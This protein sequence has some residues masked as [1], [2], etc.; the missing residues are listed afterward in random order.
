MLLEM[1]GVKGL[2]SVPAK[3]CVFLRRML[4]EK[5]AALVDA[6]NAFLAA[7]VAAD[8]SLE[9]IEVRVFLGLAPRSK[10]P[11]RSK[12]HFAGLS[13]VRESHMESDVHEDWLWLENSIP[14]PAGPR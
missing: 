14:G 4:P 6:L 2:P 7:V 8:P 5:R 12:R 13:A 11:R 1:R 3:G 10:S 9:M